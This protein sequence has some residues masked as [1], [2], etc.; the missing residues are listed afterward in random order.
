MLLDYSFWAEVDLLTTP[1][2]RR[3][4]FLDLLQRRKL[5]APDLDVQFAPPNPWKL[6]YAWR[7]RHGL[8]ALDTTPIPPD[9]PYGRPYDPLPRYNYAAAQGWCVLRIPAR[10]LCADPTIELLTHALRRHLAA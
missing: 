9:H 7:L 1:A 6:D 8:V 2:Q 4:A 3:S 10:D 5:P